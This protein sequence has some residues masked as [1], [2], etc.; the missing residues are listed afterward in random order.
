MSGLGLRGKNA[1]EGLGLRVVSAGLRNHPN[2]LILMGV[3]QLVCADYYSEATQV[4]TWSSVWAMGCG[5][6]V[7][8]LG[9]SHGVWSTFLAS[10]PSESALAWP[11]PYQQY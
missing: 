4:P 5:S 1:Y 11:R 3:S 9:Y 10:T 2:G 8:S 7:W 6:R